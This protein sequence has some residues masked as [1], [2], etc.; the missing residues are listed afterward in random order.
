VK[1][2]G[3]DFLAFSGHKLYGPTGVG[4]L[5]G[6][7]HL[8]DEMDP[9]LTG[10]HMIERVFEDHS[11]WAEP[12][13]KFE[14]G[15]LPI[16]QAIALGTAVE[17]LCGI[18]ITAFHEHETELLEYAHRRLVE[19]PGVKIYGPNIENKGSIVS[20][21]VAGAHPE[22]LAMYLDRKGVHIRHGHHCTMLLH[23]FLGVSATVRASFGIY[24]Q[25]SVIDA[26]CEGLEFA[27][28]KLR[29]T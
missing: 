25:L 14:A 10:G 5:Y 4:V 26:L 13:A 29:L 19:I 23:D 17:Y 22:D 6:K 11:T 27:R 7:R 15:T 28:Q 12:P 9:F 3:I 8:L 1:S 16:A 2:S 21:T 24:N 18:G 20:F